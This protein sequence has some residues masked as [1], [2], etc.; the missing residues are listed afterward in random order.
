MLMEAMTKLKWALSNRSKKIFMVRFVC[1]NSSTT[2]FLSITWYSGYPLP[3]YLYESDFLVI[4]HDIVY[5]SFS[6]L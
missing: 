5:S 3:P 4:M 1:I 2:I 6:Q